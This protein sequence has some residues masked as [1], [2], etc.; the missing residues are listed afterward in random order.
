MTLIYSINFN[1]G[2]S[3]SNNCVS[4][5]RSRSNSYP[6]QTTRMSHNHGDHLKMNC[7]QILFCER[8]SFGSLRRWMMMKSFLIQTMIAMRGMKNWL[9]ILEHWL[10]MTSTQMVIVIWEKTFNV[11]LYIFIVS[12]LSVAL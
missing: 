11:Q 5:G 4:H 9:G 7:L 6:C 1:I 10:L 2:Q 8:R 12:S 3:T